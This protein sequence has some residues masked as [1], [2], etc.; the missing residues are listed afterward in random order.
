ME[1]EKIVSISSNGGGLS[2]I[3]SDDDDDDDDSDNMLNYWCSELHFFSIL[4][5]QIR[6]HLI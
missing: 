2:V 5:D 4:G 1:R 6:L 3:V